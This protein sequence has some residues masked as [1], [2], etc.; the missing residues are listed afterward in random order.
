MQLRLVA[1]PLQ[2]VRDKSARAVDVRVVR[3]EVVTHPLVDLIRQAG[4]LVQSQIIG[5][6]LRLHMERRST[7]NVPYGCQLPHSLCEGKG[8]IHV[9]NVRSVQCALD[10]RIV[11]L[12]KHDAVPTCD[13]SSQVV[14]ISRHNVQALPGLSRGDYTDFVTTQTQLLDEVPARHRRPVVGSGKDVAHNHNNQYYVNSY[15]ENFN[16]NWVG[17]VSN[18]PSTIQQ[19]LL[20]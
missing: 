13:R 19:Q 3:V 2:L 15:E 8:H 4:A 5:H 7:G 16:K 1:R 17:Q 9:H 18:K 6:V 14:R 20:H 11:C 10:H 12:A